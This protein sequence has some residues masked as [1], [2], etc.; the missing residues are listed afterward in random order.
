MSPDNRLTI[1]R[2]IYKAKDWTVIIGVLTL[3]ATYW[4]LPKRVTD[5]ENEQTLIQKYQVDLSL[6]IRELK[7]GVKYL[8]REQKRGENE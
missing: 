8:V 2:F 3:V 1:S 6:D 5:L 7:T 4:S